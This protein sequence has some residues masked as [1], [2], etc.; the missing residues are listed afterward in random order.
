MRSLELL[1]CSKLAVD[2]LKSVPFENTSLWSIRWLTTVCLLRAILHVSYKYDL[3]NSSDAS[4][5]AYWK[6]KKKEDIFKNFI[7]SERNLAVKEFS[8][9]ENKKEEDLFLCAENGDNIT[10]KDGKLLIAEQE[11]IILDG[12]NIYDLLDQ[13]VVW[14]ENYISEVQTKFSHLLRRP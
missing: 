10:D 13:A 2:E 3:C 14:V 7:Q 11:V 1:K 8:I 9:V 5:D 12:Q 4:Y 6:Q